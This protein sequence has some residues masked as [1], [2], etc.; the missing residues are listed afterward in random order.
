[1][2]NGSNCAVELGIADVWMALTNILMCVGFLKEEFR[3]I[4]KDLTESPRKKPESTRKTKHSWYN[5]NSQNRIGN[6]DWLKD[7]NVSCLTFL[8]ALTGCR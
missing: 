5:Q 4:L 3:S 6:F 7:K 1:M 8:V 2:T